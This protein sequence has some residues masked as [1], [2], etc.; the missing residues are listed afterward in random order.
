MSRWMA[1]GGFIGY[2]LT[3]L[4]SFSSGGNINAAVRDGMVGCL[5]M[6]L[7]F[8]FLYRQLELAAVEVIRKERAA[9]EAAEE[10]EQA[11]AEAE[12][13]ARR[14]VVEEANAA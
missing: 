9:Q 14:K 3:L 1:L 12:R 10:A 7:L 13:K 6:A 4:A 8:Q 11:Q 5:L 2:L